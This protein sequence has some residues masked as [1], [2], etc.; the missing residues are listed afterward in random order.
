M[1]KLTEGR[2]VHYILNNGEHRPAMV[3]RNWN[4]E[5]ANL[6]VFT[7]GSNDGSMVVSRG[8]SDLDTGLLLWRTSKHHAD[9]SLNQPDTWHFIEQ[10]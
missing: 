10:A 5:M 6:V 1:E 7:D 2:I 9:V 3:V 8:S 4:G